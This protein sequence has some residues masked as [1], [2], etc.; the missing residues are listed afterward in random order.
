MTFYNSPKNVKIFKETYLKAYK[1]TLNLCFFMYLI[2]KKET[3]QNPPPPDPNIIKEYF[4]KILL[5]LRYLFMFGSVDEHCVEF[6]S[7]PV[8]LIFSSDNNNIC[9]IPLP[10][11]VE[12]KTI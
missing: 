8:Y 10:Q 2:D 1:S 9:F 7:G 3:W 6:T 5:G 4:T 12:R 11:I